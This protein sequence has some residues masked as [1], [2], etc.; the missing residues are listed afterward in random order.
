MYILQTMDNNKN[1]QEQMI[2]SLPH[3][4]N[5]LSSFNQQQ[6]PS[7]SPIYKRRPRQQSK[8]LNTSRTYEQPLYINDP[9][10]HANRNNN[11]N[12]H[13]NNSKV[14]QL[15]YLNH[16]QN[17]HYNM[18]PIQQQ[19]QTKQHQQQHNMKSPRTKHLIH[20]NTKSNQKADHTIITKLVHL[21]T[22]Q[23]NLLNTIQ[24][25]EQIIYKHRND[26]ETLEKDILLKG[27]KETFTNHLNLKADMSMVDQLF[28]RSMKYSFDLSQKYNITQVDI[29]KAVKDKVNV[30][31]VEEIAKDVDNLKSTIRSTVQEHLMQL[32]LGV[33]DRLRNIATKNELK[34]GLKT[35][36]DLKEFEILKDKMQNIE[37]YIYNDLDDE[38]GDGN[39][40]GDRNSSSKGI[41]S[42]TSRYGTNN[43]NNGVN[44]DGDYI[45]DTSKMPLQTRIYQTELA[46]STCK[47]IY[48]YISFTSI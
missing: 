33:R 29:D 39:D 5:V 14:H 7:S 40:T 41:S 30:E 19:Q 6:R 36:S 1:N 3:T 8:D 13:I 31:L 23:T 37:K 9:Y 18:I 34:L 44:E 38:N 12:H 27:N 35:K 46:L 28:E 48:I 20:Q 17:I 21:T 24:T 10:H 43:N 45:Q 16:K 32:T 25:L 22:Q 42:Y 11:D 47:Y 4:P 15:Y 26:I 2:K